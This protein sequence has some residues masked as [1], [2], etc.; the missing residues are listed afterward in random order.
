M[1]E[2]TTVKVIGKKGILVI[3]ANELPEYQTRG[4]KLAGKS[5][6][7]ENVVDLT[8]YT[9]AELKEFAEEAGVPDYQGLKKAELI[10]ALK[11]LNFKPTE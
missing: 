1:S 7:A 11:A 3:N 8:V 4:Y 5:E 10:D 9:V 2:I 6:P